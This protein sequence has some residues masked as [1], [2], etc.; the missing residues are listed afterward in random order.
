MAAVPLAAGMLLRRDVLLPTLQA[1]VAL[2][3]A[4][5]AGYCLNDVI[6]PAAPGHRV[7]WW[8]GNG[9]SMSFVDLDTRLSFAYVPNKWITGGH[10]MDRHLRLLN[11]VY[12]AMAAA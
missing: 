8:A 5:S 11:E 9:G 3:L 1:F 12:A 4:A 10:E 7:A 6:V 2:C